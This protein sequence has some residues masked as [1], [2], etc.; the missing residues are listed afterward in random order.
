MSSGPFGTVP[1]GFNRKPLP[2]ILAEVEAENVTTFG[3]DVI[4]SP[5]SPLGQLNGLFANLTAILWE[6]AEDTYQSYDPDQADGVRLETLGRM[7]LIE[8]ALGETDASLRQAIT[9]AGR[10]RID[11]QDITRALAGL[12]GVSYVQVFVNDAATS[13]VNGI[14]SHSVAVAVLG[15]D[16]DDVA[17]TVRDYVVPGV[18]TYGNTRVD[19]TIDGFCRSIWLIR[20]TLVPITLTV[21]VKVRN[22]RNGCP[23]PAPSAIA[24]GLAQELSGAQAPVNGDDVTAYLVRSALERRYGNVEFVSAQAS[25]KPAAVGALPLAIGF[26]EIA[27]FAAA[28]VTIVVDP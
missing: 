6:L 5:Q 21:H 12:T 8:R 11:M 13:D 28:D 2:T 19:T 27:T 9:N 1:Q 23:P 26:F 14:P 3:P 17:R 7:R 16:D 15:G 18:G 20:P 4:Q 22:D 10:A 25:R 24:V